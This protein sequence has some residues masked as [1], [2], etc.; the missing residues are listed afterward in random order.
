MGVTIGA[1]E[2]G[3]AGAPEAGDPLDYRLYCPLVG[4][5]RTSGCECVCVCV[6]VC[7]RERE[8]ETDRQTETDRDWETVEIIGVTEMGWEGEDGGDRDGGHVPPPN[9]RALLTKDTLH[10]STRK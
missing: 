9:P 7:K 1:V 5:G 6:C 8:R 3:T 4:E 2:L 10:Q